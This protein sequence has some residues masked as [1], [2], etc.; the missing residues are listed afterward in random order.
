MVG[1]ESL[2]SLQKDAST[3]LVRASRSPSDS[4][5]KSLVGGEGGEPRAHLSSCLTG[6]F[7]VELD[8]AFQYYHGPNFPK[9]ARVSYTSNILIL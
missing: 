5:F 7:G 3:S 1:D 6:C 2:R 4:I 8:L 9:I